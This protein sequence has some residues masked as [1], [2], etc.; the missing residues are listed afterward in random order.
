LTDAPPATCSCGTPQAEGVTCSAI[1]RYYDNSACNTATALPV[2]DGS[3]TTGA[4]KAVWSSGSF[5]SHTFMNLQ[6]LSPNTTG[7]RCTFP[8]ATNAVPALK[9]KTV[10]LA[11]S[12]PAPAACVGR[13]DCVETPPAS[14]PFERLCIYKAGLEQCPSAD[15]PHAIVAYKSIEDTRECSPCGANLSPG[16]CTGQWGFSTSAQCAAQSLTGKVAGTCYTK[17]V[18]AQININALGP[19]ASCTFTGG[20]EA[21]GEVSSAEPITFCC[22]R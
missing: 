14:A 12:V 7:A 5:P 1:V 4:C 22:N 9:P 15:Y 21:R 18:G 10:Q 19:N 8:S 11:C 2:N 16:S 20:G 3:V 17:Q 13:S 6:A